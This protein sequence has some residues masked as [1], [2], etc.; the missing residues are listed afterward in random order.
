M[1]FAVNAPGVAIPLA[2][3]IALVV[4]DPENVP[5]GIAPV[6]AVQVT[7]TFAIGLPDSETSAA[8]GVANAVPTV[9]P[10]TTQPL[11]DIIDEVTST[12]P[13]STVAVGS[14]SGLSTMRSYPRWA[15]NGS[16]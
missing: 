15:V 10:H 14:A 2:F 11:T 4:L 1:V 3:V 7:C 12:A 13:M 9:A 8:N 6:G 5:V 16:P